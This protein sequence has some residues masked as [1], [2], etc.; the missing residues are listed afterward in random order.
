M[1]ILSR[2][3][4]EGKCFSRPRYLLPRIKYSCKLV[5]MLLPLLAK[6]K[7]LLVLVALAAGGCA[8]E[9]TLRDPALR[10]EARA[11]DFLKREVPAWSKDNGCF[12][13]H[14]NGDAARAL[15]AASRK[16]YR[17][18]PTALADTTAWLTQPERWAENKGDPGFSDQRLA[19]LQ[20]AA[21]LVAAYRA[22]LVKDTEGL[23]TAA[24]LIARDQA[25]DG[26][27]PIEPHNVV[28]S[29]ATYGTTL[30]T[31][32]GLT[33]LK[34]V[35]A[36][37]TA[38]AIK[39]AERWLQELRP[40]NVLAAATILLASANQ[41]APGPKGGAIIPDRGGDGQRAGS[42]VPAT[43]LELKAAF[44]VTQGLDLI[45]RAQTSD[46]GW[47]PYVDSPPEAFDTALVLLALTS[48]RDVRRVDDLIRQGRLFLTAQ[49]LA[50]GSW[51]GTTRPPNGPSYAQRLSTTGWATLALLE[52]R[53]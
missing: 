26:T 1:E 30:A 48:V 21:A 50:D 18:P 33:T 43:N 41:R 25:T 53:N 20:F 2:R 4:S 32:L 38:V 51:P 28:G 10:A 5:P 24:Q 44:A 17:V 11:I 8:R 37:E 46:G 42:G 9:M 52:T 15:Y 19:N 13:C 45:R 35:A 40:D 16:G 6:P 23:R 39:R 31:Y 47:G 29:P 22:G 34:E 12:S 27:W 14:N 49:Q 7:P 36:A 3:D